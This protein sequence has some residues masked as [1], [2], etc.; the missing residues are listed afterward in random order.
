MSNTTLPNLRLDEFREVDFLENELDMEVF[1]EPIVNSSKIRCP[2]CGSLYTISHGSE[3]RFFRDLNMYE[4]GSA[5][6]FWGAGISVRTVEKPLFS[7]S[8][9]LTRTERSPIG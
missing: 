3:E 5:L 4:N 6:P 2:H 8:N 9:A 1:V 7:N